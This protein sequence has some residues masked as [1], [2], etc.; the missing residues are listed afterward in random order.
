[1]EIISFW[2]F[3]FP[4]IV[5]VYA[6]FILCLHPPKSV[7][8]PSLLGG[9][10]VAVVN[11]VVDLLAY[12]THIWQY[13]LSNLVFHLPLPFYITP[14]LVYG[15]I[16]YLLIW[17]FW[18]GRWRWFAW[19][20]LVGVPLFCI[21]KDVTGAL[22]KTS[23]T[24]W[25]SVPLGVVLTVVMWAAGFYAGYLLFRRLAP[26]REQVLAEA[27]EEQNDMIME[28]AESQARATK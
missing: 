20:L 8:G 13:N 26:T 22:A 25:E 6:G 2:A 4:F 19:L 16:A 7:L 27:Q 28:E 9:V 3:A 14:L 10:V 11:A 21:I 24:V 12:Y 1:M 23:Y 17:R 15:S 18:Q 5:I